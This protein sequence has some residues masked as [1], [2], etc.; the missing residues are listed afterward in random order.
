MIKKVNYWK[1]NIINTPNHNGKRGWYERKNYMLK[2]KNWM[3]W[4]KEE[5][6]CLI[7]GKKNKINMWE[8]SVKEQGRI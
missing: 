8:T 6:E 7:R 3:I 4:I 1:N 5:G 2:E